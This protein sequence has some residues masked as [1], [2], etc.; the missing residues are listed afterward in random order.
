MT[1]EGR[2]G[3]NNLVNKTHAKGATT[4]I[5]FDISVYCEEVNIWSTAFFNAL[6]NGSTVEAACYLADEAVEAEWSYTITTNSWYIAGSKTQI[7]N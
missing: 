2:E 6:A 4:V 5:G 7:L 1:G 3:A